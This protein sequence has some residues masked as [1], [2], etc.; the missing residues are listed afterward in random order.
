[1]SMGV[2]RVSDSTEG[3]CEAGSKCC[4]HSRKGICSKGFS[5]VTVNGLPLHRVGDSGETAC[6]H[7]GKFITSSGSI[8][9]TAGGFPIA[10]MSD[11]TSCARCGQPGTISRGSNNVTSG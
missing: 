8:T 6:P 2:C 11:K 10:R 5:S 4:P 3:I 9:V 7:G 1:M